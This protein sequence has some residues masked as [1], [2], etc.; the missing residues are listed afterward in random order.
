MAERL[1]L[2]AGH[3]PQF[4]VEH[5]KLYAILSQH[6]HELSD[7]DCRASFD[8]VK[9]G[10]FAIAEDRLAERLRQQHAAA[11]S[12]AIVGYKSPTV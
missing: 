9:Q 4:L 3:L 8:I 5:A 1:S 7:A 2:L 12:K 11:A 10:I 6:L